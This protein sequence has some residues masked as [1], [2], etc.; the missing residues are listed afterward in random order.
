MT[1]INGFD[2]NQGGTYNNF[3][4]HGVGIATATDSL[5][6]IRQY[7]YEEKRISREAFLR[8]VDSN[9][10]NDPVLLHALRYEAPKLGNNDDAV[11]G[12]AVALLDTFAGAFAGKRN[13][14]A[15]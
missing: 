2:A 1:C 15:D 14:S 6:A 8:A 11:D 5:A 7:V 9:F 13:C 12:I 3:G 10:E 4:I